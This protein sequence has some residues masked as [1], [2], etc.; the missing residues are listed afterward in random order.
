MGLCSIAILVVFYA[1]P[2]SA[3]M[4]VIK[5]RDASLFNTPLLIASFINACLWTYYGY[6]GLQNPDVY[7]WGPNSVGVFVSIA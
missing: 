7:I 2:L 5:S 3:L 6:F 4:K 1:A